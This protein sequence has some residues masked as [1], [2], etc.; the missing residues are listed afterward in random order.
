MKRFS[1]DPD[2]FAKSPSPQVYFFIPLSWQLVLLSFK[3]IKQ[4]DVFLLANY[5]ILAHQTSHSQCN[6]VV[7]IT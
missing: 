7:V 3:K 6:Y 2:K 1:E 5:V 4:N